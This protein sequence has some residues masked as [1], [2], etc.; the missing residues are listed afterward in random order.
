MG[1]PLLKKGQ[2]QPWGIT[3]SSRSGPKREQ[4]WRVT[5]SVKNQLYVL[6][7]A[8]H[9]ILLHACMPCSL[10]PQ[11]QPVSC[12]GCVHLWVK[13]ELPILWP[14]SRHPLWPWPFAQLRA[15]WPWG[16]QHG[17]RAA[18]AALGHARMW[19]TWGLIQKQH[20]LIVVGVNGGMG[21]KHDNT[22]YHVRTWIIPTGE[23]D[24]AK[25]LQ[26]GSSKTC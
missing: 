5:I 1:F 8:D 7:G 26:W 15:A 13:Q 16:P 24:G 19:L 17:R 21:Y 6:L 11:P 20:H 23:E 2:P 10:S 18:D 25:S 22:A 14:Q 12:R 9:G 3:P 4:K